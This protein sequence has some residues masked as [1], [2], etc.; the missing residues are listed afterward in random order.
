MP[1]RK[2]AVA[3]P[4]PVN[5]GYSPEDVQLPRLSVIGKL[6]KLIDTGLVKPGNIAIGADSEDEDSQVFD[7]LNGTEPVRLYVL[8]MHANYACSFKDK[9]ADPD[10]NGLW[11][12]GDED[13]PPEAKRQFNYTLFIPD[14]STVL[15]V[16]YTCAATA[17]RE[18]RK[19]N[20][21]LATAAIG[22]KQTYESCFAM[23]TKIYTGGKFSW[24]GPVFSLAEAVPS[25]VA[26]A[27]NMHDL[28]FGPA[29]TAI[30]E[31]SDS[32]PAL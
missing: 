28:M 23:S 18:G 11:E 16:K 1:P 26:A 20:S 4:E 29:R 14:H 21:K 9:E 17:A 3:E 25:E 22:G 19:V 7:A 12:E 10:L 2:S 6:S 13:M 32:K 27:K 24:P 31:S 5:L 15:P 8:N 30:A